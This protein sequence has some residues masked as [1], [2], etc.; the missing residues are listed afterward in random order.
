MKTN[1]GK[2]KIHGNSK[3][4][5]RDVR[6]RILKGSTLAEKFETTA[7]KEK[8]I[9]LYCKHITEGYSKESFEYADPRT[10]MEYAEKIDEESAKTGKFTILQTTLIHRALRVSQKQWEHWGIQGMLNKIP[11][12]NS[13]IWALNMRNRFNWDKDDKSP[14]EMTIDRVITVNFVRDDDKLPA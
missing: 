12:F 7:E 14:K 3:K 1:K 9:K 2:K 13:Q 11:F 5:T 4:V 8:L 6:G 10:I